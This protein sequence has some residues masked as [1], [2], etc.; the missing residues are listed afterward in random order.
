MRIALLQPRTDRAIASE[1]LSSVSQEVGT[2]PPL[3]LLYLAGFLRE[4]T[5]HGVTVIDMDAADIQPAA[6]PE[7]LR[8]HEAQAVGITAITHN[9]VGVRDAAEAVRSTLPDLPVIVGGP[10][11]NAF[12]AET[13]ALKAIDYAIEGD[14]ERSLA[15]LLDALDGRGDLAEVPGLHYREGNAVR[16]GA[17]PHYEEKLDSL[18]FPARDLLP[19]DSYFYVLGKRATFATV[20]SSRGCPFRCTFCSTPHGGYRHRSPDNVVDEMVRCLELGAEEIHFVDDTFNLGKG[21]R[22]SVSRAIIA[23][24]LDVRWSFRG[25]ADGIDD[26][27]MALAKEAG[28]VRVHLGV[29]TGTDEG[30]RRL[31]KGVTLDEIEQAIRLARH[32]GIVSA[33][34]FIL[35]CPHEPTVA[36]VWSTVRFAIRLDPDF[37]MFNLL[38]IYPDTELFDEAVT[39]GLVRGDLWTRFVRDPQP[40]FSIPLWEEHLDRQTLQRLLEKA[41]RRFYFR[42]APILRNLRELSSFAELRRKSEAALSL[43]LRRS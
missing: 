9:L 14:G 41:Y 36:D 30:L 26:E 21:R 1:Q 19:V 17:P 38:A 13:L 24:G 10:H 23:R 16:K 22:A 32:H 35:G 4:E 11:V 18:P 6:L 25:R 34:Y 33:A 3:G 40:D 39:K 12:G 42:P 5:A 8:R 2:F 20:L 29:E 15:R 27:G 43:L 7:L 37:A 31:R 28:C